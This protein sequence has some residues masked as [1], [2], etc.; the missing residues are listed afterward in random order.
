MPKLIKMSPTFF[1]LSFIY[2][3]KPMNK[4]IGISKSKSK[5]IRKVVIVVPMLDPIIIINPLLKER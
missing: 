2:K 1:L 3:T 5:L 4:N